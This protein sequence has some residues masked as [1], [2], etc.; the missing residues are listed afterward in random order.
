MHNITVRP[1]QFRCIHR[2][3]MG[4]HGA[5]CSAALMWFPNWWSEHSVKIANLYKLRVNTPA[6]RLFSLYLVIPSQTKCNVYNS[7]VLVGAGDFQFT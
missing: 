1:P 4:S 3:S 6:D 5:A 2:K 7:K